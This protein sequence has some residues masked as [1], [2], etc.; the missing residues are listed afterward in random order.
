LLGIFLAFNEEQKRDSIACALLRGYGSA[1]C[2]EAAFKELDQLRRL[3]AL[4]NDL[5][6]GK[7]PA[8]GLACTSLTAFFGEL[9][10]A[11]ELCLAGSGYG[12]D[13]LQLTVHGS[14]FACGKINRRAVSYAAM[15]LLSNALIHGKGRTAR[16]FM[17][18]GTGHMTLCV[19]NSGDFGW[20]AIENGIKEKGHGL[21][22][23]DSAVRNQGGMLLFAQR[24]GI[25][26]SALV[27]PLTHGRE[28]DCAAITDC[29]EL[30]FDRASSVHVGL[31]TVE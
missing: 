24:R 27:L 30:L 5:L 6:C 1:P 8:V 19:E 10:T 31:C 23:A 7:S 17:R 26:Q 20:R 4:E 13:N 25:C 29:A 2:E 21:C 9:F 12:L 3:R 18:L 22:A 11:A 15:N 14:Q 28:E 16:V